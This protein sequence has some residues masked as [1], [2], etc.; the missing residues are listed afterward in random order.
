MIPGARPRSEL[1]TV[2]STLEPVFHSVSE[3]EKVLN[4]EHFSDSGE[5]GEKNGAGREE[6]GDGIGDV[7]ATEVAFL[8][9]VWGGVRRWGGRGR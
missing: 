3:S 2:S 4:R 9:G 7:T 8:A 1:R 6:R 5:R